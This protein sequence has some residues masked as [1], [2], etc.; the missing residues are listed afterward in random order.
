M[1]LFSL[2]P[3]SL[4][5]CRIKLLLLLLLFLKLKLKTIVKVA[6][7]DNNVDGAAFFS[8]RVFSLISPS[9]QIDFPC[10]IAPI[11]MKKEYYFCCKLSEN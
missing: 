11:M 8:P 3:P 2:Y 9:S 1:L 6:M 10:Q 7:D 5:I 4:Q